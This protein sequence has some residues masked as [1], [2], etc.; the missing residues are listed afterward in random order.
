MI[1]VKKY[2]RFVWHDLRTGTPFKVAK[3]F[4]EDWKGVEE[5]QGELTGYKCRI[6]GKEYENKV[7]RCNNPSRISNCGSKIINK[8]NSHISTTFNRLKI[9]GFLE[10]LKTTKKWR[11]N[12]NAFFDLER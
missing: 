2:K 8:R 6:C 1:R 5:V 7:N 3:A 10:R 11:L 9:S 12:L 4:F